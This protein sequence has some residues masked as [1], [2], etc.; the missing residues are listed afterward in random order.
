MT[1][2]SVLIEG[3]QLTKKVI[4][5]CYEVIIFC[6][7]NLCLVYYGSLEGKVVAVLTTTP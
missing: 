5:L 2:S 3:Y 7:G 1:D 4:T 6:L